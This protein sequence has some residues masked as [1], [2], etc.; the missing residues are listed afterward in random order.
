MRRRRT[1]NPSGD[2]VDWA[3]SRS[4]PTRRAGPPQHQ[5]EQ[6][7]VVDRPDPGDEVRDQVDRAH[8]VGEQTA[9]REAGAPGRGGIGEQAPHQR[10]RGSGMR[11]RTGPAMS[12]DGRWRPEDQGEPEPRDGQE[13]DRGR[14]AAEEGHGQIVRRGMTGGLS[15][16]T[17]PE[18]GGLSGATVPETGGLSGATAPAL[19]ADRWRRPCGPA[20]DAGGRRA[21]PAARD[22]VG[23]PAALRRDLRVDRLARRR[24]VSGGSGSSSQSRHS[25]SGWPRGRP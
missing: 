2:P 8:Q 11:R 15:G 16:A 12:R 20:H 22:R 21:C 17:A 1:S 5:R 3:R 24:P 23:G 4:S 14:H 10:R 13:R 18:T 6:D 7:D 9:E 25:T 19:P